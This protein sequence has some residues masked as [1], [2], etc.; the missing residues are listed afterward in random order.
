MKKPAIPSIPSG[1]PARMRFDSTVKERLEIIC[2]DRTGKIPLLKTD[3]SLID[4][5]STLNAVISAI[6]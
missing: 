3:A 1:D 6:Q 5:I 2:G 4:V